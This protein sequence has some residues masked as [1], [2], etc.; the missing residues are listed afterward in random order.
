[1]DA[2][3]GTW[4]R[5]RGLRETGRGRATYLAVVLE[6]LGGDLGDGVV[7]LLGALGHA[8]ETSGAALAH[9]GEQ[10]GVDRLL[11][12]GS[13]LCTGALTFRNG[14]REG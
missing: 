6:P 11:E 3:T 9:G 8:G 14:G 10:V 7:L 1:M 13:L 5:H 2:R 12:G 4:Q